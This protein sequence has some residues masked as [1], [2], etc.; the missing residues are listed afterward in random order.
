MARTV[1]RKINDSRAFK[2]LFLDGEG[3]L[4]P[5]GELFVQ[6]MAQ[7][8]R[9]HRSTTIVSPASKSVDVPAS[10]QAEGRREVYLWLMS[11]L[12][13]NESDLFRLTERMAIDE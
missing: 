10:F 3:K 12:H 13:V 8:C 1:G 11:H 4:T 5:D 6:R 7:F 2:R 9:A